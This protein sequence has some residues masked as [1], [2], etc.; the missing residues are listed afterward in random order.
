M[1]QRLVAGATYTVT[2]TSPAGKTCT[3]V[4]AG[5]QTMGDADVTDVA[6]TCVLPTHSVSGTVIGA[7]YPTQLTITLLYADSATPNLVNPITIDVNPNTAGTYSIDIPE[8]KTYLMSVDSATTNEVCALASKIFSAP[9]T[10]DVID[11]NITCSIAAANTYSFSGTITGLMNGE[12]ISLTL[13]PDGAFAEAKIITADAD[14]NSDD[15]F[16]FNTKLA[17]GID[18]SVFVSTQPATSTCSVFRRSGQTMS[19]DVTDIFVICTATGTHYIS[20]EVAGAADNSQITITLLHADSATPNLV[21]P[22]TIDVTPNTAGTYFFVGV[23]ENSRY[24]I[25][26]A[27]ATANEVCTPRDTVF[28][29][30]IST[31]NVPI[32]CSITPGTTYSIGGAI[33]GLV[34]GESIVL[35]LTPTG[36]TVENKIITADADATT[37]DNYAFDTKLANGA[38][39]TVTATTEPA[40]K[41]CTVD[42]AGRQTMG[43][44]DANI[45]VTCIISYT[46]SSTVTGAAFNNN[47]YLVLMLYDDSAGNGATKRSDMSGPGVFSF[48]DIP[49]NKFYTLKAFS[50]T[51]GETCSGGPTT[52]A[53]ITADVT[54]VQ[55]TCTTSTG[56]AI[57]IS[58]TS[59]NYEASRTTVNVFIGDGAIPDTSGTPTHVVNGFDAD[60]F[61]IPDIYFFS[62][63]G[64]LHNIPI[65]AG[66]YYAVTVSTTSTNESCGF[67]SGGTGG[68]VNDSTTVQIVC[69]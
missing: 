68:P 46:V 55:I 39:Y 5:E 24:L 21:N 48:S 25:T 26:I 17:S 35:T 13:T 57:L 40:G 37:A 32:N 34:N 22:V 56:P 18:Y 15:A 61:I 69:E 62:R 42:S 33:S 8:N 66:K 63:D 16:S 64:F 51:A 11:V 67:I 3:I 10:A 65:D 54:D 23:P 20:G 19:A 53:P 45:G 4:P 29:D 59:V 14:D 30:S 1:T 43:D 49:A 52:P 2:T 27:S 47:V 12:T 58:L 31:T 60:V 28:R 36:G 9:I 38:T 50:V 6:V 41:T 7:A 44:T